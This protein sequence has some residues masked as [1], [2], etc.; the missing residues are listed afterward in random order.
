MHGLIVIRQVVFEEDDLLLIPGADILDRLQGGGQVVLDK[1]PVFGVPFVQE[2]RL[3]RDSLPL[4][5]ED[6]VIADC[7]GLAAEG[8]V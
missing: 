3:N 2:A 1:N 4:A 5:D 7:R 6:G 8:A